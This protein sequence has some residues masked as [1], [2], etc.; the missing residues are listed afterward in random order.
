MSE[1]TQSNLCVVGD[2]VN[3]FGDHVVIIG[4]FEDRQNLM[5]PK[6]VIGISLHDAIHGTLWR[7]IGRASTQDG[8]MRACLYNK[9]I[10]PMDGRYVAGMRTGERLDFGIDSELIKLLTASLMAGAVLD[11]GERVVTG[12]AMSYADNLLRVDVMCQ[13]TKGIYRST[14]PLQEIAEIPKR[15]V[16]PKGTRVIVARAG[17]S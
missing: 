8:F 9:S 16:Q 5:T 3:Y 6:P 1:A 12:H 13:C 17:V 15:I 11:E 10:F 4:S 14:V 7:V 2:V